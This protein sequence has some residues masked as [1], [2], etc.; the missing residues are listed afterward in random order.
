[1]WLRVGV[2][3]RVSRG[4]A[5]GWFLVVNVANQ[6]GSGLPTNDDASVW[7]LG[8]PFRSVLGMRIDTPALPNGLAK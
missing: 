3:R 5:G 4:A 6:A 1:M 8:F 2:L 7:W